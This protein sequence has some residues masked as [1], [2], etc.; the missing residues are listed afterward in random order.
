MSK[1]KTDSKQ[2]PE[3]WFFDENKRVYKY[4]DGKYAGGPIWREHWT[5]VEIVGETSRSWVTSCG[6]KV[7][8]AGGRCYAFSQEDID[9]MYFVEKRWAIAN[10]VERCTDYDTLKAIADMVGY[11]EK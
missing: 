5:K 2:Y 10:A 6:K 1:Q 9:R 3:C 8:K 11:S 7:P 4:I